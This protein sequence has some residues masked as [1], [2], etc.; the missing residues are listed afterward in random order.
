MD[1]QS[2]ALDRWIVGESI[3]DNDITEGDDPCT[4]CG[5]DLCECDR[6]AAEQND[7][8]ESLVY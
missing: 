3:F 2:A 4:Y 6:L 8:Y 1:R 7:D 5:M